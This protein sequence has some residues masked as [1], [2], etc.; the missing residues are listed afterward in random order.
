[1][2]MESSV[3]IHSICILGSGQYTCMGEDMGWDMARTEVRI[4]V[5][6]LVRIWLGGGNDQDFSAGRSRVSVD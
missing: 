1:M 6:M 3:A 4:W 2:C 5:R